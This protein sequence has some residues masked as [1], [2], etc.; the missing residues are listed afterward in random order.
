MTKCR[1]VVRRL[2]VPACLVLLAA[3]GE[4]DGNEAHVDV[5][6]F[7]GELPNAPGA[8]VAGASQE[9]FQPGG[10]TGTDGS[11]EVSAGT[12]SSSA[13]GPPPVSDLNASNGGTPSSEGSGTA[14]TGTDDPSQGET[15]GEPGAEP[16][17]SGTETGG[18]PPPPPAQPQTQVFVLFGQSN[19]FGVPAPEAQD[20]P[21][22][23]RAEVLSLLGCGR[24][25]VNQWVPAQPPLH[26]CVGQPSNGPFGPGLGPGDY[27]AK[28]VTEAFPDDTIL[29]VP[30]AI[31]AVSID[32][33]QPG[34]QSY[35]SMLSRA[36][37]AQQRGEIRGILFHQGE[38]NTND[39]TWVGKVA[40]VVAS[41]RSDLGV[42]ESVPFI[43]GELPYDGCCSIHNGLVNQ[44]PNSIPNTRIVSAQGLATYVESEGSSI[45]QRLHFDVGAQRELGRRY[46]DTFL[47]TIAD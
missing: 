24:H 33:F 44:L 21:V 2:G 6:A 3:C 29:L 16:D 41:L 45:G 10:G 46:G 8:E 11:S 5:P 13:E 4:G 43:A 27:F 7:V 34:Q 31:A 47:Q 28:V 35:N 39:M 38:T 17:P 30:N 22:T 23:A 26:G 1:S 18:E 20:L 37:L 40:Q 9:P 15:G 42:G 36:R 19:M 32:V 12:G 25:A 14:S